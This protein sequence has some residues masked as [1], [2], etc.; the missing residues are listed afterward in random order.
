MELG[1]VALEEE[2]GTK[3]ED[4]TGK[5]ALEDTTL[6]DGIGE[7]AIED[8]R[9]PDGTGEAALEVTMLLDETTPLDPEGRGTPEESTGTLEDATKPD[10]DDA[11]EETTLEAEFKTLEETEGTEALEEMW[12]EDSAGVDER[13]DITELEDGDALEPDSPQKVIKRFT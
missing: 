10:G 5:A 6:F 11:P 13:V 12:L 4:G 8:T 3:L 1:I 2:L 9:L 7:D